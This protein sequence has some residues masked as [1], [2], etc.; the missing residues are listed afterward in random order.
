MSGTAMLEMKRNDVAMSEWRLPEN[1]SWDRARTYCAQ[2]R[3]STEAI[4]R[5]GLELSGLKKQWFAQGKNGGGDRKSD[6]Y[7][8]LCDRPVTK[9]SGNV[10]TNGQIEG[11]RARVEKELG[12]KWRTADRLIERAETIMLIWK[13]KT[14]RPVEYIS[15]KRERKT[16]VPT[17]EMVAKADEILEEIEAGTVAAPRAWAGLIG[18]GTRAA[19]GKSRAEVDHARNLVA[20]LKK[21]ATS[22]PHWRKL[23]PQ[24]RARI[25]T[26][27]A[28]VRGLLPETWEV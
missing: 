20:G 11:W 6:A 26:L 4:V 21:L 19:A 22:L 24:A 25:E 13:L 8:S 15:S 2:I 28:A 10:I 17:P 9:W 23:D 16:V 18:E 3:Q 14:G 12:I 1:P 5:L 27:W 7:K